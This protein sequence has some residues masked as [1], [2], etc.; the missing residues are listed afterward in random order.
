MK[1]SVKNAVLIGKI[2][3]DNNN[4]PVIRLSMED[5]SLFEKGTEYA[6]LVLGSVNRKRTIRDTMRVITNAD[7]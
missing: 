5:K 4:Y 2:G 6:I 3:I 7:F 1:D